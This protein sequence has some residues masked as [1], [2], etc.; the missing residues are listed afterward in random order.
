MLGD[1]ITKPGIYSIY[2]VIYRENNMKGERYEEKDKKK[3]K[4]ISEENTRPV[5]GVLLARLHHG[6]IG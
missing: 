5:Y 4:N 1:Q 6:D 2:N 3:R